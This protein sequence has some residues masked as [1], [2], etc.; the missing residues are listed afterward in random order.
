MRIL[1][2][3][4]TW[5][6]PPKDSRVDRF[7]LLSEHL[8][9]DI[10]QPVW[11]DNPE[12]VEQLYG[13]GAYPVFSRDRFRYHWFLS[14]RGR[15]ALRRLRA[16]WF[17]VRQG[18]RIHRE[19]PYDCIV[20]YSHMMPALAGVVL[21][22]L[23]GAKLVVEIMTSPAL[24]YLYEHPRRTFA[25]RLMRLYSDLSLHLTVLACDRVRL[26]YRAQLDDYP[27]LRKR[28][29][30]AFHDFVTLSLV[31]P[32]Q[33][34]HDPLILFVGAPWFLKGVDVLIRAFQ[35][36]EDEF[37]GVTLRILGHNPNSPELQAMAAGD[38]RIE[39]VRA[40]ENSE[41]LRRL[42]RARMLVLPSRCEGMGRVLIEAMAAGLPVV[43]STAGGIP[44]WIR[45]GETGLV[46]RSGDADELADRLRRL[47]ADP[48]LCERMGQAGARIA[49]SE[50]DEPAYVRHFTRM[51]EAAV[52]GDA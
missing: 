22:L 8:E 17:Y 27:L 25:D 40:V 15:A 52:R 36:V 23:T 38:P 19:K 1:S 12:S 34:E 51:V 6:P 26:L 24:S 5:V 48:A 7:H 42:P 49:R 14:F 28:R 10:L 32:P 21:K 47:L 35:K 18:L 46:F 11:F 3:Q 9:G 2:I 43:G 41:L 44:H 29:A 4:A 50:L 45:D 20:V 13:E 30:S 33:A 16:F 39:I 37:P 31:P